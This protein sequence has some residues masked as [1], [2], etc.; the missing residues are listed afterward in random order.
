MG[1]KEGLNEWRIR[2]NYN[3]RKFKPT[4]WYKGRWRRIILIVQTASA[5]FEKALSLE[6]NSRLFFCNLVSK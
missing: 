1:Q 4:H 2:I 6:K 3:R 5:Q